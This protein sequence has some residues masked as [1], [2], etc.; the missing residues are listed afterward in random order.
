M[1]SS[2]IPKLEIGILSAINQPYENVD[3]KPVDIKASGVEVGQ[4]VVPKM[5]VRKY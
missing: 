1:G 4:R 3:V 5:K 2:W